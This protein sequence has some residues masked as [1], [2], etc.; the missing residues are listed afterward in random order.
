M[1]KTTVATPLDLFE[2]SERPNSWV[3]RFSEG[4][5]ND[6]EKDQIRKLLST[7]KILS[8]QQATVTAD[9]APVRA[10]VKTWG[11]LHFV[12]RFVLVCVLSIVWLKITQQ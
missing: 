9:T 6:R 8:G 1:P 5:V 12:L 7:N 11:C 4:K 2:L 3:G 10:I